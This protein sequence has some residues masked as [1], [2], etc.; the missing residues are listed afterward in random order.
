MR[1]SVGARRL[2]ARLRAAARLVAEDQHLAVPAERRRVAD[3]GPEFAV[4]QELG[5]LLRSAVG[6][7][8]APDRRA[9]A[10]RARHPIDVPEDHAGVVAGVQVVGIVLGHARGLEVDVA[11]VLGRVERHLDDVEAVAVDR[12]LTAPRLP[13]DRA[14]RRVAVD[15]QAVVAQVGHQRLGVRAARQVDERDDLGLLGIADVDDVHALLAAI[16][17]RRVDRMGRR[18]RHAE[19]RPVAAE[20]ARLREAAR[21]GDRDLGTGRTV[22][23]LPRGGRRRVPRPDD[24]RL[25]AAIRADPRRSRRPGCR[26]CWSDSRSPP[27]R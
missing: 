3:L 15:Q 19:H 17:R 4:V 27:S 2:A 1:S 12:L 20:R 25:A 10:A 16:Q 21:V 9:A 23:V 13:E 14:G 24:Q 8:D 11:R 18:S 6:P 5:V 26:R 7:I 22:E